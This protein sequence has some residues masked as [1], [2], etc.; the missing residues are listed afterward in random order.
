MILKLPD[1]LLV[2]FRKKLP[3]S[4]GGQVLLIVLG[5]EYVELAG[6]QPTE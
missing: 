4:T 5:Q 2:T 6:L 1:T 3:P